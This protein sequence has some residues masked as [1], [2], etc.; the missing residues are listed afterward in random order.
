VGA[1]D[2]TAAKPHTRLA[3]GASLFSFNLIHSRPFWGLGVTGG[4][5]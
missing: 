4:V 5:V 3:L 2:R 1:K